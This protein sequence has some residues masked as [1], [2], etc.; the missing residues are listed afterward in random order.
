[1]TL[2][3]SHLEQISLSSVAIAEL[4]YVAMASLSEHPINPFGVGFRLPRFLPTHCYT[5]MTS[6]PSFGT[7]KCMNVRCSRFRRQSKAYGSLHKV[8]LAVA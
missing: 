8:L 1:M 3:D 6:Q 7:Q 2:L 4:P 5:R